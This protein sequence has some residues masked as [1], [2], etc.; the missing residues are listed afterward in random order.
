MATT[1]PQNGRVLRLPALAF[2]AGL[3]VHNA[4]HARR[5]LGATPEAVIWAGTAVAVLAAVSLTLVATRHPLAPF[6]AA[7]T[8]LGT[9]IG[10][11]ASH[12]LPAWGA[13]SDPL[14]GGNVDR[15]TWLAVLAE[16]AGALALGLAGLAVVRRQG[17][18]VAR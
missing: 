18:A 14:P 13:L 9:A 1:V 6:A 12:L 5:G 4:D 17:Y 11:S 10:V 7:A 8:G 15:F 16:V 2:L 3:V